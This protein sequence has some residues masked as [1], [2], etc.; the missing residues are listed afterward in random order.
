M[1]FSECAVYLWKENSSSRGVQ[2]FFFFQNVFIWTPSFFLNVPSLFAPQHPGDS[3]ISDIIYDEFR[4]WI[5]LSPLVSLLMPS[6]EKVEGGK[7][8]QITTF[9]NPPLVFSSLLSGPFFSTT[10]C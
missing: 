9:S 3:D 6:P 1:E 10:I 8:T 7:P 5:S 4:T 2:L